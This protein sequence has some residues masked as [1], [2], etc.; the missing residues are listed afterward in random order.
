MASSRVSASWTTL[1]GRDDHVDAVSRKQQAGT[2][3]ASNDRNGNGTRSR[4]QGNLQEIAV[5]RLGDVAA[6]DRLAGRDGM[7]GTQH[8]T[9]NRGP[10]RFIDLGLGST[11]GFGRP[12]NKINACTIHSPGAATPSKFPAKVSSLKTERPL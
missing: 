4:A 10:C 8:C 11:H 3:V 5:A 1:R 6:S 2:C 9:I 7:S 12:R